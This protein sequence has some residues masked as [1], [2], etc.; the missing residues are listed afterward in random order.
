MYDP[1]S[2]NVISD[3][4]VM[5]NKALLKVRIFRITKFSRNI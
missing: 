2:F 3:Y 5:F 4:T 1:L